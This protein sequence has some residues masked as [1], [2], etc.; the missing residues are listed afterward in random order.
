[1]SPPLGLLP[2]APPLACLK[3][4]DTQAHVPT[5]YQKNPTLAIREYTF[6][7]LYRPIPQVVF[8]RLP[9][10]GN[11]RLGLDERQINFGVGFMY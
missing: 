8:R 1:M 7:A 10:Q 5:G 3:S 11:R 2:P 6:G 4:D 9:A